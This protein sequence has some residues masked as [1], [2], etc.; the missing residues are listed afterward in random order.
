MK[1]I[2][3]LLSL[4]LFA[5]LPVASSMAQSTASA[6]ETLTVDLWPDYDK[7]AVLVLLTGTLPDDTSL[8][9]TVTVPLPETADFNVVA[10]IDA[11]DGTMKDDID[12]TQNPGE[13]TFTT[14]DLRFRVEFYMPY[15]AND[16]QRSFN[17]TWLAD[18]LVN[19]LLVKVQQPTAAASLLTEP[20]SLDVITDSDGFSYHILPS[21]PVPAGQ[22]YSV[23]VDYTMTSSQL[24]AQRSSPSIADASTT[25]FTPAD[26]SPESELPW[27]AIAVAAV[28]VLAIIAATWQIAT[29]RATARPR[30]PRPL[31]ATK[32]PASASASAGYCHICGQPLQA[33]DK[34]CRECGTAVKGK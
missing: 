3:L 12:F 22:P 2:Q 32:Q 9:A 17:F 10:R 29:T 23:R 8:P 6:I 31:R 30:K 4:L 16:S 14:P 25:G 21:Q 7:A 1:R 28:G 13:V 26:S 24:S 5:L 20:A 11:S 33:G 34:F 18:V 15:T 27:P 19:D